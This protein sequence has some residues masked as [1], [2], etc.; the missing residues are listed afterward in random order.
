[1]KR[2]SLDNTLVLW[3]W[4]FNFIIYWVIYIS[5]IW[6]NVLPLMGGIWRGLSILYL[7]NFRGHTVNIS[8]VRVTHCSSSP[9]ALSFRLCTSVLNSFFFCCLASSSTSTFSVFFFFFLVSVCVRRRWRWCSALFSCNLFYESL[10]RLQV[11]NSIRNNIY[12]YRSKAS[13]FSIVFLCVAFIFFLY[14]CSTLALVALSLTL[15]PDQK[16]PPSATHT[17]FAIFQSFANIQFRYLDPRE[18]TLSV[19]LCALH[20]Y[21]Y[22]C[23]RGDMHCTYN[24]RAI[25]CPV[26]WV[27]AFV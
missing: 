22:A 8:R 1:M 19:L 9:P 26:V 16:P 21:K 20:V 13:R 4:C 25:W 23:A 24:M 6:H 27:W 5:Y 15:W 3:L 17:H 7:Y 18:W 2:E 10:N 14:F 11:C 12:S